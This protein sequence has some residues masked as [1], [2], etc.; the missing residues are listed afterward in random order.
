MD[1]TDNRDGAISSLDGQGGRKVKGKGLSRSSNELV[2]AAVLIDIDKCVGAG[3]SQ[4]ERRR[5]HRGFWRLKP[6]IDGSAT[7]ASPW[8][9]C[10]DKRRRCSDHSLS[11]R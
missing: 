6:A 3:M 4:A 9:A 7:T 2:N 10:N 5:I 11:C 1:A 8:I